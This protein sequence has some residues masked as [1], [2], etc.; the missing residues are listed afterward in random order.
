MPVLVYFHG[1]GFKYGG[2]DFYKPD[3]LLE[4]SMVGTNPGIIV[5][6]VNYRLGV[7]GECLISKYLKNS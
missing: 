3:Y 4:N 1:G 6:T 7:L 5:V 2:K